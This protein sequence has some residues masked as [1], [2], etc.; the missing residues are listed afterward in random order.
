MN[1]QSL[2]DATTEGRIY[3]TNSERFA[4]QSQELAW[5]RYHETARQLDSTMFDA[6]LFSGVF[7]V[8]AIVAAVVLG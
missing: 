7:A 2:T 4:I 5:R 6:V 8:L 1:T 3:L